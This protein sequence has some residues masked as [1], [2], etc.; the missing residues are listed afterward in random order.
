MR[1]VPTVRRPLAFWPQLYCLIFLLGYPQDEQV[2]F[3]MWKDTLPHRRQL[4]WDLL[5]LFPNE[6][7]PLVCNIKI[8][9]TVSIRKVVN[10]SLLVSIMHITETPIKHQLALPFVTAP[11]ENNPLPNQQ[12][13]SPTKIACSIVL[14]IYSNFIK[15]R[16]SNASRTILLV[17]FEACFGQQNRFTLFPNLSLVLQ[18][19]F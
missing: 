12:H 8:R 4:V 19:D 11:I 17:P 9:S 16:I 15:I 10:S 1:P 13:N 2:F 3:W 5:C 14:C 18:S 6:V 7:V